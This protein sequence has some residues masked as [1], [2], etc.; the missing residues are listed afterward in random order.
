MA[1]RETWTPPSNPP[2]GGT[3]GGQLVPESS[4][5]GGRDERDVMSHGEARTPD[6]AAIR[7]KLAAT[8]GRAYWRSLEEVAGS[9]EFEHF[10]HSEFP[11][12][13]A[14]WDP[15]LGRR[16]F[17]KLMSASLALAGAGACTRQPTE[18]IVPYVDI[19]ELIVPGRPLYFATSMPLLGV[20]AGVLA[21]SHMG[22]PTKL[23]GNPDHP[24]S[25]GGTD[26]T[27]QASVL[28]LYDPDRAQVVNSVGAIRP[29]SAFVKT[30]TE[31]MSRQRDK[32]GA[33]LRLL[34]GAVTS[35]TLVSL[36]EDV[37]KRYPE[38]RWHR[39]EPAAGDGSAGGT[40]L[41]FGERFDVRYR[42]DTADVVVSL[43][44]EFLS[45]G[46]G[47]VRYARDFMKRRRVDGPRSS[48]NRLYVAET[49]V[50]TTGASADHRLAVKPSEM[51]AFAFALARAAGVDVKPGTVDAAADRWIAAVARDLRRHRGKCLVVPGEQQPAVVHALAH[52]I[53][54]TLG[55]A[56]RTVEYVEPAGPQPTGG[57]QSLAG[58]VADMNA[59]H[60]DVLVM[61]GGNPVYDAPTDLDFATALGRVGLSVHHG[62]HEDET[63]ELCHWHIPA[64]HY[65]ETWGDVC[66]HDGTA[67]V[68]QPLI[69]PLYEAK[70]ETEMIAAM[71]GQHQRT[72]HD[73]VH[74]YW[75]SK[76]HRPDFESFWSRA[77]HD[78]VI[79]G[80]T[81]KA[82][83]VSLQKRWAKLT[84]EAA[85]GQ[86]DS[87]D[88]AADGSLEIVFRPCPN[89]FDGRF[90][91]NAWLQ[92][93]PRPLTKLTWD[94]AAWMA[95]ATAERLH[96]ANGVLVVLAYDGRKVEAPVWIAPGQPEDTVTVHLGYGRRRGGRVAN[97]VGFDAY[98]LRTSEQPWWGRGLEVTKAGRRHDLVTTQHHHSMEGR[99]LVRSATLREYRAHPGFAHANEH[100]KPEATSLFPGYAYDGHA[101]GMS[102]DLGAC[103]G[104]NACQ[105]ACQA[106]N[107]IAVVG[108][109]QVAAGRE[110]HWIRIDRYYEG[111]LDAPRTVHQPVPCMQCENAP[112]EVV[113]PVGA[114]VHSS[115]GLNDMVYNRC[116]G[117]R[118]CSNNCPYKVRRFNFF[119]FS[120]WT[121]ETYK[122]QRNPDV[123]VRSRG[124][125]EKCTY[126]I[127]R[128]NKVRIDAKNQHREI[129][130]GEILTACQ[131]ACPTEAIVFGDLNDADSK[132]V[133]LKADERNYALLGN[134]DTRPRTTYLA[135]VR[136]P[137]PELESSASA[138]DRG[139]A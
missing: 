3:G 86:A 97:G 45:C 50:S 46:G 70:T 11:Q 95:P 93:L 113:C 39:Y 106:E 135:A 29:W 99:D 10:L 59:G 85:A 12:E 26:V 127:Q 48:M 21:E 55:N 84:A 87:G 78:G 104:C 66:A 8:D 53:N 28:G 56:G 103:I 119:L 111:S 16:H 96:L 24:S 33:G 136:N 114:T 76:T 44:S 37:L 129:R 30:L 60:V 72:A 34:T 47:N 116:V 31:A 79:A 57:T 15:K 69:A 101:W 112:C 94:N 137:N 105:I 132:V 90:A 58:L 20:G 82:R 131:Q 5:R 118:Y 75:K 6:L 27:T 74:D 14:A 32:K 64:T 98:R 13:A 120:D 108:K 100:E 88:A 77:L 7:A 18:K 52:A 61:L 126:C 83:K 134:L 73:L 38:A 124:V 115:E 133:K 43:D 67:A 1:K 139:E 71:L 89:V 138:D 102:I 81:P 42:F 117:T 22:R 130:D 123:T 9:E 35:P 23:E 121:T 49:T 40:E 91:N 54:V 125:M 25:L 109:E 110:M 128:I 41:A 122:M 17:L 4:D 2:A 63:S 36:L 19:P 68:I 92:E 107:N 65:L 62:L 51:E 80:T